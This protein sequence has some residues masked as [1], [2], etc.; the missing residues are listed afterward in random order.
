MGK[1]MEIGKQQVIFTYLPGKIFDYSKKYILAKIIAIRGSQIT[2][3]NQEL[4]LKKIN[5]Y[6]RNWDDNLRPALTDEILNKRQDRFLHVNPKKADSEMFPLVFLCSNPKC[7]RVID[8]SENDRL[9]DRNQC[10]FCHHGKLHQLNFLKIHRCGSVKPLTPPYDCKNCHHKYE[11]ALDTRDSSVIQNFVWIC[12]NC[13]TSQSV[14]AGNCR[15]CNWTL[16]LQG[17]EYPK[18]MDIVPFRANSA[19]YSHYVILLN[20]PKRDLEGFLLLPEWQELAAAFYFELPEIKGREIS[21]LNSKNKI[22]PLDIEALKKVGIIPTPEQI[23]QL[24]Q[25]QNIDLVGIAQ[26][27]RDKTGLNRDVWINSGQ[28]MLE[29]ILCR[30]KNSKF[31]D[32]KE[33]KLINLGFSI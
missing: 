16:S 30:R 12:T 21:D 14:R 27:L 22:A 3:I 10:P 32:L 11:W 15:E 5:D 13:G 17:I 19:F 23:K 1:N 2:D 6:V 29:S 18:L 25:N 4:V 24:Q 31:I 28:E 7:N 9:P 20:L 33:K 8:C 26:S